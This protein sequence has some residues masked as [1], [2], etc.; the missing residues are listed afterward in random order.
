MCLKELMTHFPCIVY[1]FLKNYFPKYFFFE[2]K[3][4]NTLQIIM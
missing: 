4:H 3:I 2:K 1:F